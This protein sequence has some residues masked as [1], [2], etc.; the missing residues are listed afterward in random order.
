MPIDPTP[1]ESRVV[2]AH[3]EYLR[4]A[5]RRGQAIFVGRTMDL[6]P[7]GIAVFEAET[8][9]DARGFML[10]DPAVATGVM[11]AELRPFRTALMRGRD[12]T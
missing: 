11:T 2:N 4:D 8:E 5:V 9:G 3:F 12:N 6:D 1:E 7:L 10:G